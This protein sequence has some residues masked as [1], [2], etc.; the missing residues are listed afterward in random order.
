MDELSFHRARLLLGKAQ[1]NLHVVANGPGDALVAPR[2]ARRVHAP[3]WQRSVLDEV[4]LDAERAEERRSRARSSAGRA[5]RSV[6]SRLARSRDPG[7]RAR[8]SR[9]L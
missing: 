5:R 4:L 6:P 7:S 2:R 9:T 1:S 3:T 8:S